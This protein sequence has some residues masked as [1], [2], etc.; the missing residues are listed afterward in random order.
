MNIEDE[1]Y[2]MEQYG[3][4]EAEAIDEETE[5]MDVMGDMDEY[6][7]ADANVDDMVQAYS[8]FFTDNE[9]DYDGYNPMKIEENEVKYE[10]AAE[11]YSN[12][13]HIEY[14]PDALGEVEEARDEIAWDTYMDERDMDCC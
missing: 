5:L 11:M 9:I 1:L 2:E 10:E 6:L 12:G 13:F 8:S 3:Q 14:T 7:G 4:T